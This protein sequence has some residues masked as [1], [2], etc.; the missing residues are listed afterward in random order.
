MSNSSKDS[1]SSAIG[2]AYYH[3]TIDI[4]RN[5]WALPSYNAAAVSDDI[6]SLP[7]STPIE[8]SQSNVKKIKTILTLAS[9]GRVLVHACC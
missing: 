9:H 1:L 4:I 6:N 5:S 3:V 8:E 2:K 7:S